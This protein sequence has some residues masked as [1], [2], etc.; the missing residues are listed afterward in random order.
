MKKAPVFQSRP[1]RETCN[2]GKYNFDVKHDVKL[3]LPMGI[4]NACVMVV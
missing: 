1:S 2:E 4:G 3:L